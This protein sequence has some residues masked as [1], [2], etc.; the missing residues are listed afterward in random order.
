MQGEPAHRLGT[1]LMAILSLTFTAL[2]CTYTRPIVRLGTLRADK[3]AHESQDFKQGRP[4]S[5][6]VHTSITMHKSITTQHMDTLC[7]WTCVALAV[8]QAFM[9]GL[10][11]PAAGVGAEDA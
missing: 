2:R 5:S 7:G 8:G 4:P 10:A 11:W 9:P 6:T 1:P 3:A